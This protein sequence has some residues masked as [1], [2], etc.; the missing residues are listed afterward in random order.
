MP[1]IKTGDIQ[2]YFE[3]HGAGEP[4][5]FIHGLGSSGRDWQFQLPVF[6]PH[7]QVI[8]YDVR[9]HGQTDKPPGPYSVP[10]FADDLKALLDALEIRK[11]HIV[12][13]SMGGMIALQLTA[14]YP[15]V[16]KSQAIVNSW[17]EHIPE[18]FR[19]RMALFQR[20]VL[21]QAFSM[22]KIGQIIAK[23]M[24]IKPEQEEIRQVFIDRWAENHK[25][26][27]MAAS[28]GMLGWSVWDNLGGMNCPSL[29]IAADEDYTP[30]STKEK[31]VALMPNAELVVIE[32]SR[33]ATPVEKPEQFNQILLD[34]LLS[35]R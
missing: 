16:V 20:L 31:F 33:H 5:V 11:A 21:F 32:D 19:Q 30:I 1:K 24:F 6:T 28:R 29:V 10:M 13:I 9:G 27:W 23:K 12:G 22:R 3:I 4:L 15:D 8:T 7:F 17:A 34:F 35:V 26:S 14:S 2:T 18:N 25:P